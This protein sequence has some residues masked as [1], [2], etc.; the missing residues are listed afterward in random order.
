MRRI[1]RQIANKNYENLG[2]T[3][4]L[5]DQTILQKLIENK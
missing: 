4:T 5:T 3:S 1:L 2:Y